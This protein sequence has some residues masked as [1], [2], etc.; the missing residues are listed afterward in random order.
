MARCSP[1]GGRLPRGRVGRNTTQHTTHV[2]V[3]CWVGR[4]QRRGRARLPARWKLDRAGGRFP[5]VHNGTKSG[6]MPHLGHL[7]VWLPAREAARSTG[8]NT[9]GAAQHAVPPRAGDA[10]CPTRRPF[11]LRSLRPPT[12]RYGLPSVSSSRRISSRLCGLAAMEVRSGTC[13]QS[14]QCTAQLRGNMSPSIRGTRETS[15]SRSSNAATDHSIP[16]LTLNR[17]IRT[18][19][20]LPRPAPV[21]ARRPCGLLRRCAISRVRA[22]SSRWRTTQFSMTHGSSR[23][24]AGLGTTRRASSRRA[25]P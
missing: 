10:K 18:R 1:R 7:R 22:S 23:S 5:G 3:C 11:R 2:H 20:L 17:V 6:R 25:S 24:C 8:L 14:R 12:L 19:G 4:R 15:D 13:L 9:P 16:C 21:H